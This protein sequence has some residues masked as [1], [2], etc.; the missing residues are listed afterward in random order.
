MQARVQSATGLSGAY[1]ARA[2]IRP[3]TG[4]DA[5][6]G[7]REHVRRAIRGDVRRRRH[8]NAAF[9]TLGSLGISYAEP[10]Y[11]EPVL[12]KPHNILYLSIEFKILIEEALTIAKLS[13]KFVI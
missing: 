8:K 12:L 4:A 3:Y 1:S 2:C 7:R 9:G 10:P 6:T 5:T 11:S 13:P